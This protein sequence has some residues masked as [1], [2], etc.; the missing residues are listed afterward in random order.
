M[1]RIFPRNPPF[2]SQFQL[3]STQF[4]R[5]RP[6]HLIKMN[7]DLILQSTFK[8]FAHFLVSHQAMINSH[9]QTSVESP[10]LWTKA[11]HPRPSKHPLEQILAN[12]LFQNK[13]KGGLIVQDFSHG[14]YVVSLMT[15]DRKSTRLNSSHVEI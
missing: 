4:P 6:K 14:F 11:E 8:S 1:V 5:T 7:S 9:S 3:M 10:R 13:R 15:P 2:P 12:P